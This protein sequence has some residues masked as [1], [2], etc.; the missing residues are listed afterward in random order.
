MNSRHI[1]AALSYTLA[2]VQH[3]QLK[4]PDC[5]VSASVRCHPSRQPSHI[6]LVVAPCLGA[7]VSCFSSSVICTACCAASGLPLFNIPIFWA[8]FF[9]VATYFQACSAMPLHVVNTR[10]SSSLRWCPNREIIVIHH[11]IQEICPLLFPLFEHLLLLVVVQ[12]S[13]LDTPQ[14]QLLHTVDP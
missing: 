2:H 13:M 4:A 9:I 8:R 6:S 11:L 10:R 12:T 7:K 1:H 5:I 14:N 3:V